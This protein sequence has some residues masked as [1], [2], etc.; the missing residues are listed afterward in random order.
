MQKTLRQQYNRQAIVFV[1]LCLAGVFLVCSYPA[2]QN[3]PALAQ[4]QTNFFVQSSVVGVCLCALMVLGHV[5]MAALCH[6]TPPVVQDIFKILR[7]FV[8][9]I[10]LLALVAYL[11]YLQ[12]ATGN[13]FGFLGRYAGNHLPGIKLLGVMLT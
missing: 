8:L 1:V 6:R 9:A 10:G 11:V 3:T 13:L 5:A 7:L 2:L 4:N 12:W